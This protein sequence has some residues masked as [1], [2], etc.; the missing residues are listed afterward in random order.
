MAKPT[1]TVKTAV[2]TTL[3]W[4][5]GVALLPATAGWVVALLVMLREP[6]LPLDA[7]AQ[8]FGIGVAAYLVAH[9]AFY[10]PKGLYHLGHRTIQI[11][12]AFLL[13]GKVAPSGA[14]GGGKGKGKGKAESRGGGNGDGGGPSPVM[15]TVSPL[16]IPSSTIVLA[17]LLKGLTVAF[18]LTPWLAWVVGLLGAS[19]AFQW[20][21]AVGTLQAGQERISSSGYLMSVNLICLAHLTV[22]AACLAF[23]FSDVSFPAYLRQALAATSHLY[24]RLTEQLFF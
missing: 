8:A 10:Q 3:K 19:A 7:A 9:L 11:I 16:L 12:T 21:M 17:L 13:A 5:S 14:G 6:T 2:V 20:A 22:T 23:L 15:M 24:S 1:S 18:D 4:L